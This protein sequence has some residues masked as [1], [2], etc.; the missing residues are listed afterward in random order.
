[1]LYSIEVKTPVRTVRV[2]LSVLGVLKTEAYFFLE[3]DFT[4]RK[5]LV[6][7]VKDHRKSWVGE[8]GLGVESEISTAEMEQRK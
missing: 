4:L 1:M 7:G 5:V 2:N 8:G 3:F 6:D